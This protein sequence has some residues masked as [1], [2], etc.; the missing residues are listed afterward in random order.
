MVQ[1]PDY[2]PYPTTE[3]T[4]QGP[5]PISVATPP[6]AFGG[7]VAAQTERLGGAV[8]QTGD[9]LFNRA[10]ALQQLNLETEAMQSATATETQAGQLFAEYRA[11]Q[12]QERVA[13]YPKLQEDLRNLYQTARGNLSAPIAK[14][15]FDRETLS[16]YNR[17]IVYGAGEAGDAQREAALTAIDARASLNAKNAYNVDDDSAV[18][19]S[20]QRARSD[21]EK[22]AALRPGGYSPEVAQDIAAKGVSNIAYNHVIGATQ[23]DPQRGYQLLDDYTKRGLFYGTDGERATEKVRSMIYSTGMDPIATDILNSHKQSDGT[24]NK[25]FEQ[26]QDEARAQAEKLYPDI[27]KI[28]EAAA[29]DFDGVYSRIRWGQQQDKWA[30]QSQ[31]SDYIL[32]GVTDPALLPPSLLQQMTPGEIRTFKDSA[33]RF[34]KE[35][36][37]ETDDIQYHKLLGM[38][39]NDRAKFMDTNIFTY[40]GLSR[41]SVGY[42][43][44]LQKSATAE[45]DPRV[46]R[47]IGWLN[48]AKGSAL[49]ELGISKS[50]DPDTYNQFTGAVHQALT[51]YQDE[52]GKPAG[53]KE[54]VNDI[55]PAV[56]KGFVRSSFSNL[57]QGRAPFFQQ[58]VPGDAM[59]KAQQY[60]DEQARAQGREP[61]TLT[62]ADVLPEYQLMQFQNLFGPKQAK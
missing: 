6:A 62:N 47:A 9:E 49:A 34:Q 53:E 59:E 11:K 57:W 3:P 14:Q 56:I 18:D 40:P 48:N 46:S 15:M 61:K 44:K 10:I 24:Y 54:V 1:V 17:L 32:R 29:K 20:M 22:Q 21:A 35:Q 43:A 45:E 50:G 38:Y 52:H 51:A 13:A 27:P 39:D 60:E 58:S 30:R 2:R 55:F 31:T 36:L 8:S 37:A 33:Y 19:E 41:A 42:F 25:S 4:E 7:T 12:G 26:M 23:R 28:G 5:R 16:T